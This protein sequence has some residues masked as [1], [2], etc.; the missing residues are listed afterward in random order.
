MRASAV[1]MAQTQDYERIGQLRQLLNRAAYTYYVL[2]A[3]EL[4]DSVYD[5]YYQELQALEARYPDAII[6]DSITQRVGAEPAQEFMS[7]THQVPLYSLDNA[8]NES[9]LEQWEK[10]LVKLVGTAEYVCELKI[11]GLALAL[12][13]QNG[14]LTQGLT[15]GNGQVGED[16][17]ANI[18]TIRSLPLQL[19][20]TDLPQTL[21]IR[22]EAFIPFPEFERI[23]QERQQAGEKLFANP[24]NACAGTLRQLDA[25]IVSA[26]HLDFFA[27]A[28]PN[29]PTTTQWQTLEWLARAGFKVNPHRAYCQ[30]LNAAKAFIQHW[31]TARHDLPY[32][33]DGV[34]IKVNDFRLQ[35]ELGFSAKAPRWAIAYKYPPAEALTQVESITIQVG[36]TGALTPVANLTPVALAGTTVARATLH[37][38]NRI[39][40]LGIRVGDSVIVRK[41]GE[42][43]PEVLQVLLEL[44]PATS[45]PFIFPEVCPECA[46]ATV[47]EDI[48]T[49]CPNPACP[50]IMRAGIEHWC[51]RPALDIQGI[52]EKLVAQLV[53]TERVRSIADLYTLTAEELSQY[54]RMGQKSAQNVITSLEAS[55]QKPWSRVLYGLGIRHVGQSIALELTKVFTSAQAL[56]QATN[57]QISAAYGIGEEIAQS[58]E[59]WFQH[60]AHQQ[61][62]IALEQA[63]I[64]L[65]TDIEIQPSSQ[66]LLGKTFVIT[67]TLPTLSREACTDMIERHG[68]K[69]T[70]SV[71]KKTSF[72]IAGEKAGSKLT[73]AESLE[74]PILNEAQLQEM[75]ESPPL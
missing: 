19:L 38:R 10:K 21:D 2:D 17:T 52:G 27:Y 13:Y 54:E 68:G 11:D 6:P 26:R 25:R 55:C 72:L 45:E 23:N 53:K 12:H 22:G 44:R 37:N 47:P 39:Q 7:V 9:D 34:V 20:T 71:S 56:S 48:L 5:Q 16:I 40:E 74:V 50:G 67:G 62:I 58:V 36:R 59:Q 31:Q 75:L 14:T 46:T 64:Q 35:E 42:I 1:S 15:R 18:R 41:A 65:V 33:T 3:P 61:L 49:R 8:F 69:V 60:P 4:P 43:I 32:G 28:V 29:A 66:R 73:K 70:N 30:D 24:R 63:G 57:Q 51:S